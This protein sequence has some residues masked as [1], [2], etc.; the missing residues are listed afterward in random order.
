MAHVPRANN[1]LLNIELELIFNVTTPSDSC[2]NNISQI[3]SIH[4]E[5]FLGVNATCMLQKYREIL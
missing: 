1:T 5:D 4:H 3:M 2:G